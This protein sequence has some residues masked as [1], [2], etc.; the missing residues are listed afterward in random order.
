MYA[1][2]SGTYH[3]RLAG[4][5]MLLLLDERM[6]NDQ[7]RVADEGEGGGEREP[8]E[9]ALLRLRHVVEDGLFDEVAGRI[10]CGQRLASRARGGRFGDISIRISSDNAAGGEGSQEEDEHKDWIGV[11]Q[12]GDDGP[13]RG[14][15]APAV[16][17]VGEEVQLGH[18]V[19]LAR[20]A[21]V[22]ETLVQGITRGRD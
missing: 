9:D 5:P 21:R 14:S 3:D 20:P 22:V 15:R 10:G 6:R 4:P 7:D 17:V 16:G 8:F 19:C 18:G 13:Q 1:A 11:L 12:N 2:A